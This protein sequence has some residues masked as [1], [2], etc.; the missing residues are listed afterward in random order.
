MN[1][2]DRNFIMLLKQINEFSQDN[3]KIIQQYENYLNPII[4]LTNQDKCPDCKIEM[5]IYQHNECCWCCPKCGRI[6]DRCDLPN[7]YNLANGSVFES[8]KQVHNHVKHFIDWI[9]HILAREYGEFEK[10]LDTIR[11]YI[12]QTNTKTMSPQKLRKM[13]KQFK[14]KQIQQTYILLFQSDY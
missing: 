7:Y 1:T 2:D 4:K 6:V 12:I 10:S 11:D 3:Q 8:K 13:L 5:E 9:D 14:T